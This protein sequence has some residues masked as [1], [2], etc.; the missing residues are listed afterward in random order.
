MR[1]AEADLATLWEAIVAAYAERGRPVPGHVAWICRLMHAYLRVA[2]WRA[3]GGTAVASSRP[4]A[5]QLCLADWSSFAD[6]LLFTPAE[7]G[8][9]I[10]LLSLAWLEEDCGLP[11]DDEALAKLSRLGE[12]WYAGS[13]ERRRRKFTAE[14][15][16]LFNE[17]L[18]AERQKLGDFRAA[19]AEAG[20]VEGPTQ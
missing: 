15:E 14:G 2:Q 8:A 1:L 9:F 10:R 18:L 17:R 4:R 16:R 19:S 3:R 7:E 11:S 20:V 12:D 5:F 6:I 13:G